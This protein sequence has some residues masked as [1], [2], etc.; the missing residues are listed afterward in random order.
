MRTNQAK[1][2]VL[3]GRRLRA[4]PGG[5]LRS[6]VC[7]TAAAPS[8]FCCDPSPTGGWAPRFSHIPQ[9]QE[10]SESQ[11]T[12]HH[13]CLRMVKPQLQIFGRTNPY[14]RRLLALLQHKRAES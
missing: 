14:P 2:A 6:N 4:V 13:E 1:S 3:G 8:W 7:F 12:T 10:G 5:A 11:S 9:Q